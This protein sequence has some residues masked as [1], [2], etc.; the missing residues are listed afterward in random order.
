MIDDF[1]SG[2]SNL[3]RLSEL[4]IDIV[5]IDKSLLWGNNLLFNSV[6]QM[7]K[8]LGFTTIIEGV[9]TREQLQAIEKNGAEM[10]QGYFF[11]RPQ[12]QSHDWSKFEGPNIGRPIDHIIPSSFDNEFANPTLGS[13]SPNI[14]MMQ[15]PQDNV[16]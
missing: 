13:N 10:M 8:N 12:P 11:G 3:S 15:D 9:E 1:G 14:S 2:Y 4:P 7:V 6:L 5:K 16:G